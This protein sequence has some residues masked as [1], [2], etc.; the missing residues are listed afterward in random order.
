M[1][2]VFGLLLAPTMMPILA[3]LTVRWLTWK[4]ALSGFVAGLV[5][6]ILMFS[7]KTWYLPHVSGISAE[8][9][10]LYI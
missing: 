8:F 10:G 5:S 2:T 4:G 3:G 6:G 9:A 1:V 7:I